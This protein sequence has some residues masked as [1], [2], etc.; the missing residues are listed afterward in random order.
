MN[1]RDAINSDVESIKNLLIE[2]ELPSS[3]VEEHIRNFIL[4][5]YENKI[6]AVGGI[7]RYGTTALLRSIAVTPEYRG[8]GIAKKLYQLFEKKAS[9]LGVD[10]LY[11][12][13]E[14][15]VEYFKKINF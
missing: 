2:N 11:L 3:D 13:T 7:E 6:I 1:F 12:L 15:A 14:S 9:S 10:M 4:A 8:N 5:E